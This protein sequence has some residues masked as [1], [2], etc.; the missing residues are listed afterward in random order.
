MQLAYCA[1]RVMLGV[2]QI[3]YEQGL[4]QAGSEKGAVAL[5]DGAGIRNGN[6]ADGWIIGS[7][8]VG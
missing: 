4:V 8:P 5:A 3:Q 1:A 7:S 6:G 2:K